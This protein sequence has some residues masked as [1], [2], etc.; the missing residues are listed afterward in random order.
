MQIWLKYSKFQSSF[1]TVDGFKKC[2]KWA[3]SDMID[4][5]ESKTTSWLRRFIGRAKKPEM[6]WSFPFVESRLF[7]LT[8]QAGF[9]GYQIF[10]GGRHVA[11][12]PYRPVN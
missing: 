8:L 1:W 5:K 10:V 12:F 2:E 7:V 11:S 9:E 3:R 4:L 6:T